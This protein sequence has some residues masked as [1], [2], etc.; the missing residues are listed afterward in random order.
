VKVYK[1]REMPKEKW[2][3]MLAFIDAAYNTTFK[4]ILLQPKN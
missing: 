4:Y 3:D 2:N 1:K